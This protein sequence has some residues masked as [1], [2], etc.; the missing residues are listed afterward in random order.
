MTK[1]AEKAIGIDIGTYALKMV[2]LYRSKNESRLTG[3]AY[4]RIEDA[5]PESL[6]EMIKKLSR[7]SM[8]SAKDVNAAVSG[9]Q[10]ITRFVNM[11]AMSDAEIASALTFEVE[12]NVPFERDEV[13]Y[14]YEIMERDKDRKSTILLAA[15]KKDNI[16]RCIKIIGSAGFSLKTIDVDSFA[17]ANAFIKNL[18]SRLDPGR[19]AALL[20]IG[21]KFTNLNILC[22]QTL[23]FSRDIQLGG[24]D[25]DET[26][27]R[28]L[29]LDV[30][31][32]EAVKQKPEEHRDAVGAPIRTVLAGLADEI[33][34]S[35]GYF[36]NRF[37]RGVDDIYVSGGSSNLTGLPE[38]LKE[39]LGAE[40]VLWDPISALTT[41][42]HDAAGIPIQT[43][44]A[45]AVSVGLAL[46]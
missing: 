21:A 24:N 45:L 36:E 30:R 39:G 35:F 43:R 15:A 31:A 26:I 11:P 38:F 16:D 5:S 4:A 27:S 37:G 46:R 7:D 42:E 23:S 3:F 32:A 20:N 1:K 6:I 29:G 41:N 44:R 25:I 22:G 40:I 17:L 33:R 2:E 10:V 28:V 8:L 13:V 18:A 9:S 34:L 19:T 14:D 12:K